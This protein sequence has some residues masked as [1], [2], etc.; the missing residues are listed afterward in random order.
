MPFIVAPINKGLPIIE[1][2]RIT[3]IKELGEGNFGNV[4][5][6]TVQFLKDDENE[7]LVAIKTLKN[8]SEYSVRQDF[9]REAEVLSNLEHK[10]IVQLFGIS[11]DGDNLMMIIEYMKFG[12]LNN[13]LRTKDP[14]LEYIRIAHSDN[15]N[16]DDNKSEDK[17][18]FSDLMKIALQIASGLDYLSS[19]HFVHR[20]LATRNCLVGDDL[21][22]KIG[23]FG[24]SRDLYETDYYK[25]GVKK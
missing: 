10:N 2:N 4:Y 21:L 19:Q 11:I 22:I 13:F 14:H 3:L 16:G 5:L 9:E 6:G 1:A 15:D 25:V 18:C 24:M 7:T 8:C 17:L 23:D 12:D 20:D